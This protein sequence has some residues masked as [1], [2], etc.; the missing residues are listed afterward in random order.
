MEKQASLWPSL[1]PREETSDFPERLMNIKKIYQKKLEDKKLELLKEEAKT[2]KN[3]EICEKSRKIV[4]KL[5]HS[6]TAEDRLF[7]SAKLFEEK[8]KTRRLI[9]N[10]TSKLNSTP[11]I[12]PL[13]SKIK[14]TGDISERLLHYKH[15]YQ[16]HA[17]ELKEKYHKQ[18]KNSSRSPSDSRAFQRLTKPKSLTQLQTSFPFTPALSR[19]TRKIAEKL[20]KSE[21]RLTRSPSPCISIA[22]HEINCFFHPEINPYS[23]IIDNRK[24]PSCER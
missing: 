7:Y 21:S 6:G 1:P 9:Q 11:S 23:A 17:K 20:E 18:I 15:V 14:R 13:A 5:N 19:K 3:P 12:S 8:I 24:N 4:A 2:I 10:I 22:N 16:E